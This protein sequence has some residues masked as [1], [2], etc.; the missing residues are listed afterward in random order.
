MLVLGSA[1]A[2]TKHISDAQCETKGI[3]I[4]MRF[5]ESKFADLRRD[6]QKSNAQNTISKNSYKYIIISNWYQENKQ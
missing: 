5:R 2:L 4:F 1:K 3:N 6:A